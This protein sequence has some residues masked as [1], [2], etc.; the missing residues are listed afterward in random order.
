MNVD[1]TPPGSS[2]ANTLPYVGDAGSCDP[3]TGGWYY[4][5]DPAVTEPTKIM[6][7]PAT[8]D[9]LQAGGDLSI[10]VGCETVVPR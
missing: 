9:L 5:T 2:T 10:R 7:C 8:C 6:M 1:H 4:D 3:T